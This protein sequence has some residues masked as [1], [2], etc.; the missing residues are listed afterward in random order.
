MT[1]GAIREAGRELRPT[2]RR[3]HCTVM[4]PDLDADVERLTSSENEQRV[5]PYFG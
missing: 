4:L 2:F 1:A 3:P 5:N